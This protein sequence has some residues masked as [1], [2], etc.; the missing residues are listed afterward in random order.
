MNYPRKRV[1]NANF[2]GC[3]VINITAA[4]PGWF[5]DLLFEDWGVLDDPEDLGDDPRQARYCV[6]AWALVANP[7]RGRWIE[8]VLLENG[9]QSPEHLTEI[10]RLHDMG[11]V[12]VQLVQ[13]SLGP[14]Q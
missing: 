2:D 8:P 7:D 6:V 14:A 9:G 1:Y 5:A 12:R 3:T 10:R 11:P 4:E 13:L